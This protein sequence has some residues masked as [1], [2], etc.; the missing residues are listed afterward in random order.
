MRIRITF[1]AVL[2]ALLVF[3]CAKKETFKWSP[4]ENPLMTLWA[5]KIDPSAP[6][7]EYPRPGLVREKWLNLNGLWDYSITVKEAEPAE[8]DGKILVPYPVESSLSGVKK[9]LTDSLVIWYSR[10]FE[11]PAE[12]DNTQIMLNFEASDWETTVWVDGKEAGTHLGGYDPFSFNITSLLSDRKNHKLMVRV[13][14]PTD[15]A[16]QPRGK[17]VS[18]PGGIW[19]TPTSGIWQTVWL[20]PVST[21]WISDIKIV[22]DIDRKLFIAVVTEGEC[23]GSPDCPPVDVAPSLTR[24]TV[25]LAGQTINSVSGEAGKP[26]EI[27]IPDPVLWSPD[28]PVLY[29]FTVELFAGTDLADLVKSYSGMRKVSLGKTADG[30]TRLMLNNS[31]VWQNG[32]LDQGFWPDGLYTPPTDEAMVYDIEM[33]KKMGFNMLRKHVKVENRRYYY[34]TDRLGMLVW[35]DMPS[36]DDYIWGDKPDIAKS[37]EDSA[38]F[39][40]ELKQMISTKFNNPSVIM[41]VIYN[42]GWGQYNTAAVTDLVM[43]FDTTRFVNSVSGWTD[44]GTGHVKDIHHYPEPLAPE[45]EDDRAIVLGEFGG[46]GLPVPGHTWEQKNWGYQ[47]M[48]DSTDLLRKYEAFYSVIRELVTEK[49]LSASVYTQTTDVETETNGLM[50]YDRAVDKMGF[51]NVRKAHTGTGIQGK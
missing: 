46:L 35:Q 23:Q 13:W 7:P 8:T 21:R 39:I 31:F 28:N 26:L 38:Q 49:G 1:I 34:H 5:E 50:T 44:R 40:F 27:S 32:P 47:K 30:Y 12:W 6:W 24:V 14:D 17:Q 25:S 51:E 29:D 42:E 33:L 22:P 3:A 16:R 18:K 36:G 2:T 43:G 4:A 20:E 41:W 10:E 15:R 48:N 45:A 19:Y 11:V 37:E 9:R